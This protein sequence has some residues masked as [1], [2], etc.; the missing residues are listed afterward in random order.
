MKIIVKVIA[1][2]VLAIMLQSPISAQDTSPESVSDNGA[3]QRQ[4]VSVVLDLERP[5]STVSFRQ[6][7]MKIFNRAD[8]SVIKTENRRITD[9]Q[10]RCRYSKAHPSTG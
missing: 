4:D 8:I 9:D 10:T 6:G 2:L 1:S 7:C 5:S 3:S